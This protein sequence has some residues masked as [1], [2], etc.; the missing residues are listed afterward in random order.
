[1]RKVADIASNHGEINF[2]RRE[3]LRGLQRS[4]GFDNLEPHGRIVGD[5]TAGDGGHRLGRLT[6]DRSR[7]NRQRHRMGPIAVA[8]ETPARRESKRD[9][10][11]E[12]TKPERQF[13]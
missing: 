10:H 2:P 4:A 11:Q 8:E 9:D 1:L 3:C 5:E 7:R 13:Y 6:V 12:E